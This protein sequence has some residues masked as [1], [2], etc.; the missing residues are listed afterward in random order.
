MTRSEHP[1]RPPLGSTLLE[2][3]AANVTLREGAPGVA[4]FLRAV[5]RQDG[6]P[7]KTLARRL[8]WPVPVAA[9]VRRELETRGYLTRR[10][11]V[12]LTAL[13]RRYASDILDH[14]ASSAAFCPTCNGA[15]CRT[16]C[17]NLSAPWSAFW[18]A[19]R[20]CESNWIRPHARHRPHCAVPP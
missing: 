20:G 9:A 3:V 19:H 8:G 10:G 13:G 6:A 16:R 17:P 4:A 18:N 11:G 5:A 12:W 2:E 7:L 1:S 15:G 14:S